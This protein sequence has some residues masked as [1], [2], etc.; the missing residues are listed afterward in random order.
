MEN[1]I[2]T[3][4]KNGSSPLVNIMIIYNR[5]RTAKLKPDLESVQSGDGPNGA[6]S[7]NFFI[8]FFGH[9]AVFGTFLEIFCTLVHIASTVGG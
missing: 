7:W 8:I 3:R 6:I 5:R 4:S 1:I 2:H 9:W